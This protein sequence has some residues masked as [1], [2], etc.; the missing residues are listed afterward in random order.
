MPLA[1]EGQLREALAHGWSIGSHSWS[2]AALPDLPAA[3]LTGEVVASA[4]RLEQ[5][6][7]VPVRHF[8]YPYGSTSAAAVEAARA[9]Y[10]TA[11]GAV[12]AMVRHD[13][14]AYNLPRIDPHDLRWA[15]RSGLAGSRALAQYLAIRRWCRRARRRVLRAG[16]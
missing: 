12:P 10:T 8:A 1:G 9:R 2:H 3:E 13:S 11:S 16:R 15:L 6:F 7:G 14:P 5:T 4:D